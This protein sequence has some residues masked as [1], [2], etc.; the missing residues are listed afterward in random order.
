LFDVTD[1]TRG[2]VVWEA[3]DLPLGFALYH[4]HMLAPN[5]K[6][7]FYFQG[8]K[9]LKISKFNFKKSKTF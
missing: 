1:A 7:P 2:L 9:I 3:K 4:T 5:S 8:K 6:A